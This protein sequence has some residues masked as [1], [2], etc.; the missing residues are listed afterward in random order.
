MK[1]L[2]VFPTKQQVVCTDVAG[3]GSNVIAPVKSGLRDE[4]VSFG[5]KSF[6]KDRDQNMRFAPATRQDP[7]PLDTGRDYTSF[8]KVGLAGQSDYSTYSVADM[9]AG[10][11]LNERVPDEFFPGT[12][13]VFIAPGM[14][15]D[16]EE[17]MYG[18]QEETRIGESVGEDDGLI[19][20][21]GTLPR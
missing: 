6:P 8:G 16:D 1:G 12:D 13:P 10:Y 2:K 18:V 21:Y 17:G 7:F 9:H 4:M 3:D 15:M 20:D 19:E 5:I 11:S 14:P